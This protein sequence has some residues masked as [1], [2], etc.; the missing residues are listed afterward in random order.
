LSRHPVNL[1][2]LADEPTLDPDEPAALCI[3]APRLPD[4][5]SSAQP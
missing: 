5:R 3:L 1:T 2:R 4:R